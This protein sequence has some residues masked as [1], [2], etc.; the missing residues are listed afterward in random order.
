MNAKE[1]HGDRKVIIPIWHNV[2][3]QDV[4]AF[5][6]TLADKFAIDTSKLT[7]V[8]IAVRIIEAIR[9]DV[10]KQIKSWI[11]WRARLRNTITEDIDPRKIKNGPILHKEFPE[12]LIGRIRLVRA[13]LLAIYPHSMSFWL[14]EFMRDAHPSDQVEF[15]EHMAAVWQEFLAL[16]TQEHNA[17]FLNA[18]Y[19]AMTWISFNVN[20]DEVSD[21]LSILTQTSKDAL[22]QLWNSNIPCYDFEE[23]IESG[24]EP[25]GIADYLKDIDKER[26]PEDLP[27]DLIRELLSLATDEET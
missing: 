23:K 6:P 14:D 10:L 8:Q 13:S 11:A 18:A 16:R 15:W 22:F 19:Q 9:P 24:E 1:I 4:L 25:S 21:S 12:A 5:S 26:F 2:N 7:V 27:E 20:Y 3:K 17:D